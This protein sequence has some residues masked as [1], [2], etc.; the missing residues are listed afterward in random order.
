MKR[1]LHDSEEALAAKELFRSAS[2]RPREG[3]R[4]AVPK[5]SGLLGALATVGTSRIW[6]MLAL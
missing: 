6:Y 3:G 2:I 5:A 1:C 4:G